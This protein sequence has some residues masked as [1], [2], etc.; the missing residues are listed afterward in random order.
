MRR[1]VD[2]LVY[3]QYS[4]DEQNPRSINDQV[5]KRRRFLDSLKLGDVETIV[6]HDAAVS[7]EHTHRPGIDRVW[8]LIDTRACD[9]IVAEDVSCLYRRSTRAMQ[10][11]EAAVDASVRVIPFA[12]GSGRML[13]LK[14]LLAER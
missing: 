13:H 9:I 12:S 2:A 8:E 1:R 14:G 6:L 7:G 3:A 4:T 11:V 10:L 5:A